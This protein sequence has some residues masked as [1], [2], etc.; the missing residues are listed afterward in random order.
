[1]TMNRRQFI[2]GVAAF[3]LTSLGAQ[4][5][6]EWGGPIVDCHH[7]PKRTLEANTAH[8][9]GAGIS[10]AMLLARL[11]YNRAASCDVPAMVRALTTGAEPRG[12]A[13]GG[14]SVA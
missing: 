3:S 1:M 2:H 6:S 13:H 14:E 7:H 9:D 12:M 4:S 5:T 11:P 8:L 10:N